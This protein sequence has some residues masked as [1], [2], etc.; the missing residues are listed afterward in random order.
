MTHRHTPRTIDASLARSIRR[1]YF[2]RLVQEWDAAARR[3]ERAAARNVRLSASIDNRRQFRQRLTL[4]EKLVGALLP[5]CTL[6]IESGT[7]AAAVVWALRPEEVPTPVHIDSHADVRALVLLQPGSAMM[8]EAP[9]R[10]RA[11]A[12]DRVV[13]RARIVDL[14]I[15]PE[16]VLAALKA[17]ANHAAVSV[18]PPTC[19]CSIERPMAI[20]TTI[21]GMPT[22]C[23]RM[24]RR[25]RWYWAYIT[26]RSVAGL[27]SEGMG[28]F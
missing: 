26:I 11:H 8:L 16:K 17:Q 25:S 9:V 18:M 21:S 2:R 5:T 12:V 28:S 4:L 10:V 13:Q 3:R 24:L 20:A 15:T 27:N 1:G 23:V 22:R 19:H 6:R 7:R 14:P